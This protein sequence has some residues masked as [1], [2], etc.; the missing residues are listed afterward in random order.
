MILIGI[1]DTDNE[2]SPGTG[3]LARALAAECGRHGRGQAVVSRHQFLLDPRIA[4]TSHN[5]G[6]CVAIDS[7]APAETFLFA[8]DFVARR[9]AEGSDPGV[10]VS[11]AGEVTPEVIEFGWRATREVVTM[12]EAHRL[13]GAAGVALRELGGTGLGI[14]G[15]LASVGLRAGGEEGRVID[16]PGLRELPECVGRECL[17]RMGISVRYD[18]SRKPGARDA[19]ETLGW[20]RPRLEGG[21]MVWPV[22]WSEDR[23]A[24]IPVDR[25][26]SRPLD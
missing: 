2:T 1:D 20:V 13:A 24:W 16:L 3:A 23:N 19:H 9:S 18:S 10:C 25:K 15:A 17:T 6:A 12:D 21:R 26:R 4:F 14:I 7:P 22:E 11:R 5:S 8:M